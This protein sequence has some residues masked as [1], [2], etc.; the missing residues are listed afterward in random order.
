M[1]AALRHSHIQLHGTHHTASPCMPSGS[2]N[3]SAASA[4]VCRRSCRSKLDKHNARRRK[5]R[6]ESVRGPSCSDGGG[7]EAGYAPSGA[8]AQPSRAFHEQASGGGSGGSLPHPTT[9]PEASGSPT[10]ADRGVSPG[11]G[12]PPGFN[13]SINDIK[14]MNSMEVQ[15][16]L[17]WLPGFLEKIT[18]QNNNQ[19]SSCGWG[20]QRT[21]AR[22]S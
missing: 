17:S 20:V 4:C 5:N 1:C 19:V 9:P 21:Q 7:A 11:N 12:L 16:M 15:E 22:C 18:P 13:V 3:S 10:G 8:A 6:H 2:A 14:S